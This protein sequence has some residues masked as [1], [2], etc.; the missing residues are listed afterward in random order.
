[1]F[2]LSEK[3]LL[4]HIRKHNGMAHT[5]ITS[6]ELATLSAFLWTGQLTSD[7]ITAANFFTKWAIAAS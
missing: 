2:G 3:V 7:F 1:L 4:I 6:L 5:N